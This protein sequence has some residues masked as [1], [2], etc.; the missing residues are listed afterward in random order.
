MI[1]STREMNEIIENEKGGKGKFYIIVFETKDVPSE[2]YVLADL[3]N[4]FVG[5][6]DYIDSN[7]ILNDFSLRRLTNSP[8]M[9][10]PFQVHLYVFPDDCIKPIS[11]DRLRC[12]DVNALDG[13]KNV[14]L[15]NEDLA[16]DNVKEFVNNCNDMIEKRK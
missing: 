4:S 9:G 14:S 12:F 8:Y 6:Q 1:M 2:K 11:I 3:H 15:L 7:I 13:L 10:Q 16:P 5:D